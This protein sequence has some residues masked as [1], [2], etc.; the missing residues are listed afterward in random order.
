MGLIVT[1]LANAQDNN[2]YMGAMST[3]DNIITIDSSG[4]IT[5]HGSGL[6]ETLEN[7]K[8]GRKNLFIKKDYRVFQVDRK[9]D[10]SIERITDVVLR[11]DEAIDEE[12]NTVKK[13]DR[14]GEKWVDATTTS[15]KDH[16]IVS[17]TSCTYQRQY[18]RISIFPS[19]NKNPTKDLDCMTVNK[20]ICDEAETYSGTFDNLTQHLDD[21][22]ELDMTLRFAFGAYQSYPNQSEFNFSVLEMS[23]NIED[24]KTKFKL[25]QQCQAT[26]QKFLDIVMSSEK[27]HARNVRKV[28]SS[29]KEL[30]T[31]GRPKQ[32]FSMISAD[33]KD[34]E[35]YYHNINKLNSMCTK[36]KA[37][38]YQAVTLVDEPVDSDIT[39]E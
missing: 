25:L 24:P 8:N 29:L 13:I 20:S 19:G 34:I 7:S 14:K 35:S 2:A 28:K 17:Q 11:K 22:M 1:C 6:W 33:P 5:P 10:L 26:N 3:D 12:G 21:C 16:K 9:K 37:N 31:M 32:Y 18:R 39:P 15:Y 23:A 38:F 30:R 36:H 4:E 27:E